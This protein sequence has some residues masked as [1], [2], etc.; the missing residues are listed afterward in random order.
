LILE[1]INN[2]VREVIGHLSTSNTSQ[3]TKENMIRE[4]FFKDGRD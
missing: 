4:N 3:S 1:S 2:I